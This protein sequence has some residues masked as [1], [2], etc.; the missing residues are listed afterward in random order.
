MCG[1][2]IDIMKKTRRKHVGGSASK[3]VKARANAITDADIDVALTMEP[4]SYELFFDDEDKY[5][6]YRMKMVRDDM[7]ELSNYGKYYPKKGG[8]RMETPETPMMFVYDGYLYKKHPK[9]TKTGNLKYDRQILPVLEEEAEEEEEE[10]KKEDLEQFADVADRGL[11][12][13]GE[14]KEEKEEI[15]KPLEVPLKRG[16]DDDAGEYE[17]K[18]EH[19]NNQKRSAKVPSR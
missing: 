15:D 7:Y 3:T 8:V 14:E 17:Y 11:A 18:K 12:E 4:I 19:P 9:Q 10:F 6:G 13:K 16:F 2:S 1:Y 5:V